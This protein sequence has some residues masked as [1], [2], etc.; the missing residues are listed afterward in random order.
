MIRASLNFPTALS[1]F[2]A[3]AIAEETMPPV[4][5]RVTLSISRQVG[6]KRRWQGRHLDIQSNHLH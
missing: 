1:L 3:N 6:H 5:R 4:L 2:L